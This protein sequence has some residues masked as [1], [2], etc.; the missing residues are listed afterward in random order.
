MSTVAV[1][2]PAKI[3]LFLSVVGYR[4]DSFHELV[5]LVAPIRFGDSL[6]ISLEGGERRISL[7]CDIPIIPLDR[8]NLAWR[9]VESFREALPFEENVHISLRKR[10]P[11]GAGL[12]GGSSNAVAVLRGLNQLLGNPLDEGSLAILASQLGSDCPLFL[13]GGPSMMRGRGERIDELDELLLSELRGRE[14]LLFKP[15]FSVS[16]AWAYQK[17]ASLDGE[18]YT[19][20]EVVEENLGANRRGDLPLEKLMVNSFQSVVGTKFPAIPLLLEQ[21]KNRF[22]IPFLMSGSGSACFA[23]LKEESPVE[24]IKSTIQEAWGP[25]IFL[26]QTTLL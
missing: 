25:R 7:D 16:T 4:E 2:S 10:V 12:G 15:E 20:E 6:W 19:E 9:A 14:V 26:E 22:E 13:R 1:F 3:N 8:E 24:E 21:L 23:F 11:I 5:S 17:L 18:A